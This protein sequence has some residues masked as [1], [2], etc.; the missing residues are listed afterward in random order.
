[1]LYTQIFTKIQFLIY[2]GKYMY[3]SAERNYHQSDVKDYHRLAHFSSCSLSQCFARKNIVQVINSLK[4]RN[5]LDS[6]K[7]NRETIKDTFAK[8]RI[9]QDFFFYLSFPLFWLSSRCYM[10]YCHLIQ[11]KTGLACNKTMVVRKS[12]HGHKQL[13]I[14]T[15]RETSMSWNEFIEILKAT[16]SLDRTCKKSTKRANERCK[17]SHH[18]CMKPNTDV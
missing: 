8:K 11:E 5:W 7:L 9:M 1:M 10:F 3:I 15:I 2:L 4:C 6:L 16:C 18:Y 14:N 13:A 17:K 12:K